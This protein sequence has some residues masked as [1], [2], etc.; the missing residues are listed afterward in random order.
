MRPLRLSMQAFGPYAGRH[1]LDFRAMLDAGLFGIYGATGSGKSTIF[2][3][4]TFALFGEAARSEQHPTTLRSQHADA[5]LMTEVELIFE[6]A[7]RHYRI[8][9]QPEQM[10]PAKRGGGE[11]R[12]LHKAWLFDVSGLDTASV[13]DDNTGKIVAETKVNA[14]NA[15]VHRLLGY[16]AA[17]FRQ[18]VL[19]PQG[20]FETFLS[21]DT[22]KRRTIL[23]ELFD[24]SLYRRLT[25]HLRAKAGGIEQDLKNRRAVCEGRLAAEGFESR[26]ALI[27]GIDSARAELDALRAA[28][29][30][31]K[32]A[33]AA[34]D[35]TYQTAAKT[36]A[37]FAEH[38]AAEIALAE[39]SAETEQAAAD[40]ARLGRARTA[41]SLSGLAVAVEGG[42][43][44]MAEADRTHAA[45][46][47]RRREAAAA[48][49]KSAGELA[50]LEARH[51]D[52]QHL[53]AQHDRY[54][55]YGAI[56]HDCEALRAEH[57]AAVKAARAASEALRKAADAHDRLGVDRGRAA[58]ALEAARS[59]ESR[60]IRLQLESAALTA[61]LKAARDYEKARSAL[62]TAEISLERARADHETA[63][64]RRDAAE[65]AFRSSEG[66]LLA[67]H[68]LH[69]STHLE[70][71]APCP[72]CGSPDHP[73]P[74]RGTPEDAD[75]GATYERAR[76]D[77]ET[78][79]HQ[80][81]ETHKAEQIWRERCAERRHALAELEPPARPVSEIAGELDAVGKAMAGLGEA[82]DVAALE[83]ALAA[84]DE[85]I[86]RARDTLEH[87]K[88]AKS[89]TETEAAVAAATLARAL[90]DIPEE[91]R[92]VDRLAA[93][94]DGLADRIAAYDKALAAAR[95]A[96]RSTREASVAAASNLEHADAARRKAGEALAEAEGRLAAELTRH[97]MSPEDF[98]TARADVEHVEAIE[99]ARVQEI[100][101]RSALTCESQGGVCA[102]CY[103]RDLAR[104][105]PVNIGEA[106]GVIAAQSIGEPGTQLT[107]RTFHI[108]GAAQRGAEISM[109][110]G[111]L[112]GATVELRNRNVVK[113]SEGLN[114]VMGRNTEIVLKDEHGR[115]K[116][117]HRV[118]YGAKLAVDD[119]ETIV[120]GQKLAEWDPYTIP[121]I[122]EKEGVAH[123]VDLVEGVSMREVLDETT[124]ISSRV[125]I[126][127]RQ[128]PK[129]DQLKPRVT[130]RDDKGEVV[131]LPNGLEARY[132]MSV[133]A[134]L[135]VDNGQQVK[136]G[137]VLA[138]IPRES[139]KTRDITGGLPRV[140]E[141]FE[142]RKPKDYAIISEIE[143]RV[144]FGRDYKTKRRIVVVPPEESG[145]EPKEYLI[146]KGKHISVQEGDYVYKGDLL[147]DGNPV[148]HDILAVMGVEAL[149]DYLINEIQDVYRLQGVKINDKHIE[150]IVRQMLQKVE[151]TEHGDTTLLV[152]EILDREDFD[153][154]NDKALK[155]DLRPA[156]A[157]PVL[158][159]I[160]KAS[161]QTKSFFSAASFQETTR[162]LTEAA[163]S[164]KRDDL[165]GLKENVIV[166]RLIPA[167]TGSVVARQKRIAAERDRV[168]QAAV[169]AR[170]EELSL[171][172][173]DSETTDDAA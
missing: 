140:A 169:T 149:A 24:V 37:A 7:G 160:T 50:T 83:A 105:T 10:R 137:D 11:T 72:V 94:T 44:A 88:Q 1:E 9:R 18:I 32:A 84:L 115:E 54:R 80:A 93:A 28:E 119:G 157:M 45:C 62:A 69:I 57:V 120:R 112:D 166:G 96:D 154:E 53:R 42:K 158:Q 71:G 20:R 143:G 2:T 8:V 91:L 99:N 152:G 100:R 173:G 23:R 13:G 51:D 75:L 61:Q 3:A 133:D 19:L 49:E 102:K 123:Y 14:V 35:A 64:G 98:A 101:I 5:D 135:S 156:K 109:I 78:A 21:V 68:A 161:L 82:A 36:D 31:A 125:V 6:A 40:R 107:M 25:E 151:I 155:E 167:G 113:N 147:M 159:G 73:S 38:A 30:R 52:V 128:Q 121:I 130:L 131:T 26:D 103:G 76:A 117:R 104:G 33:W 168:N 60:R 55:V 4:M 79:R 162:V 12:E 150:V 89:S 164:G 17:Q 163:V 85:R 153:L 41:Q 114:V 108:G 126:D 95:D 77:L 97:G 171:P 118:P 139:S 74:A 81:Q 22:D 172:A 136:A 48:A 138:R 122:T 141:L 46:L 110:E 34:A 129:G 15:E 43:T 134:I 132:F 16:G 56:L 65:V 90:K 70:P 170:Q 67:S 165:A 127:W 58:G 148:P 111:A 66:A 59:S 92:Q 86:A 39:I 145:N 116:A 27:D 106:V 63:S 87:A 144:E 142:A 146:P 124:G 29:G 47:E